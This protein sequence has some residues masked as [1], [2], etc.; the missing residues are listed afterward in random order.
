MPADVSRHRKQAQKHGTF[1]DMKQFSARYPA[2]ATILKG[3]SICFIF[4][5]AKASLPKKTPPEMNSSF[6]FG[7]FSLI[8]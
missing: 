4:A 6:F 8:R 7:W 5:N 2:C 3:V 1:S